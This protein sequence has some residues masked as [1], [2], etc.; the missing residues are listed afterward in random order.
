MSLFGET[1]NCQ[2]STVPHS[3]VQY[4]TVQYSTVQYSLAIDINA[5]TFNCFKI[6]IA[7]IDVLCLTGS[8]TG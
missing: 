8:S 3:T 7:Q 6:I 5:R 4:S 2:Y 1:K